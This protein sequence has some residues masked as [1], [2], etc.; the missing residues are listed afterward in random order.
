MTKLQFGFSAVIVAGLVMT[1]TVLYRRQNKLSAENEALRQQLVVQGADNEALSN[2]L[3]QPSPA[4]AADQSRELLRLRSE[5][6]LF[7]QQTNAMAS[8]KEEN[9][10][11]QAAAAAKSTANPDDE[12]LRFEGMAARMVNTGKQIGFAL[13]LWAEEHADVFPT[14][15]L[16]VTHRLADVPKDLMDGFELVNVGKADPDTPLAI[17]ARERVPR[18]NPQGGWERAYIMCDGFV[19]RI[20][21]PDG[22]F[23]GWEQPNSNQVLELRLPSNMRSN[24]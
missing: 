21:S 11:L 17:L 10:R 19:D 20:K 2:R 9:R 12:M 24:Q 4:P 15:L 18:P 13:R 7:R 5:V 6:G 16:S 1:A 8:L 23:D 22:N 3:R 14:D